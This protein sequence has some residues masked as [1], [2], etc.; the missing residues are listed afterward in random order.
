MSTISS[1]CQVIRSRPVPVTSPIAVA[2][3]PHFAQTARK[4]ARC[5]GS[6]T[7]I[8]RSCDSLARIA[9]GPSEASRTGT[10][11]SL[12]S[13]PAGP[14]G[15]QLGGRA[16]DAGRAQVLDRGHQP[17][18]VQLQAALDQQLLHERVAD[19]HARPL[20]R[21][22][23][24]AVL[25]S[26]RRTGQHRRTADA[27][28]PGPGP[29]QDDLVARPGG[30][31]ALQVAAPHH[32]HA[33]RVHQRVPGVAGIEGQLA[34]DVGQ[35]EAVAV[36]RD[37]A[38][39]AGQHP[40]GV[41]G[42]RR[43]EPQRVHHRD[44]PGAHREDVPDDAADPGGRA[45]VRLHV[46]GVIVRLDLEGDRVALADVHHARLLAD[47]GQQRRRLGRL[48]GELPQVHL[49]RLVR[50][51]L[52]PHPGVDGELGIGGTAAEDPPDPVVLGRGQAELRRRAG[53]AAGWPPPRPPCPG[54]VL[55]FMLP[56][57]PTGPTRRSRGRRG[58]AR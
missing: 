19:L 54:R 51:V 3:T 49:G 50:A 33:Q 22:S 27:V 40:A 41:G 1:P 35:A 37:A 45:L 16:G 5:R 42:V 20:R 6:T 17:A 29:E 15:G 24:F 52:A 25:I 26:E 2:C 43:A 38:H 36:E 48:L 28:R 10:A 34:A 9:A 14:G 18:R 7:A 56:P 53:A 44:R 4:P 57:A 30:G 32:P 21:L 31:G 13:H 11:S 58:R 23:A 39:H 8:M 12:T 47:A 55:P 46:G